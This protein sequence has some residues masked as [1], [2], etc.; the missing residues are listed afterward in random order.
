MPALSAVLHRIFAAYSVESEHYGIFSVLTY[1]GDWRAK[2]LS[3]LGSIIA[4]IFFKYVFWR[5]SFE[6]SLS[7]LWEQFG[8]FASASPYVLVKWNYQ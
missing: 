7:H 6:T 2:Q 8:K 3:E 4:Y 1:R 5:Q